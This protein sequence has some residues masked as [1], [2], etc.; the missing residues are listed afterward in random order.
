[1]GLNYAPLDVIL[2]NLHRTIAIGVVAGNYCIQY[3]ILIMSP[4]Y[5]AF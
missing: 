3:N 4:C 1:M 5:A 2:Y